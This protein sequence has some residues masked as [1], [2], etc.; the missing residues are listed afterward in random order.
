M[1]STIIKLLDPD[2]ECSK[3]KIKNDMIILHAYSTKPKLMCPYCGSFSSRVHSI[4]QREIQDIPLHEKQ[5]ILLLDTRKMYCDNSECTRKTFAERFDFVA[6]NGK[7]TKRL[8]E[9]I[10][11]TSAKLSSVNASALLKSDSVKASK[12]SICDLLK[13]N[14]C[15]CG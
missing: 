5:T 3:S 15:S 11:I 12:S 1:E 6:P 10:L 14:A 9:K 4:Y 13:K 2:L 8:V 7:K